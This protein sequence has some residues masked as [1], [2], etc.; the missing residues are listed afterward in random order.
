MKKFLLFTALTGV[1]L[2]FIALATAYYK[3]VNFESLKLSNTQA[4][5]LE[6]EDGS[7][8][9]RVKKQLSKYSEIDSLGF[10]LWLKLNPEYSSIQ[11]GLYEL[12]PQSLVVDLIKMVNAGEVKQFSIT[13]VEGQ[14]F[15][16]WISQ[17]KSSKNL[18]NDLGTVADLYELLTNNQGFCANEYRSLEGCLLPN[19]YHYT[20][21]QNMSSI[22]QRAYSSMEALLESAWHKRFVDVPLK[23]QYEVLILAS[24]VEKE[25]AVD[26]ERAEIAGVFTNRLNANMRLQTDPTVIYGIGD[27]YDGNIT[28]KH[29]RQAT[30]YNTYV[31]KGLPITP[32][33]MASELSIN[34]T[35]QP[36]LT[37][38]FYFVAS[39]E[40]G[41]VFST[42]LEEH[43]RAVRA[44]LK[45]LKEE[46]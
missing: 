26:S 45:K 19:T 5:S 43:N 11:A 39:G 16:Q 38:A 14:T 7:N 33:A 15:A 8:L 20:Y 9:Y 3:L 35:L 28:R 29:L 17:L 41:H 21:K 1:I 42:N 46:K 36:S 4:V 30:P 23:N 44:Y 40:G 37:D 27:S 32:I 22:I 2:A 34:A 18:N 31:I 6:V 24:I 13:L 10:K 12:P 25:T